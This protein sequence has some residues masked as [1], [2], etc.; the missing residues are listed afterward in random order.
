MRQDEAKYRLNNHIQ[1]RTGASPKRAPLF[2]LN[3]N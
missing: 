2:M 3:L 1:A